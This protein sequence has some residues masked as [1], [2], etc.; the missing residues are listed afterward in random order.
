MTH[1]LV[2]NSILVEWARP[3]IPHLSAALLHFVWQGALVASLAALALRLLMARSSA[4]A[5]YAVL[6]ISFALMAVCPVATYCLSVAGS[7]S[8]R[9]VNSSVAETGS[10]SDEAPLSPA[11][12]GQS[13]Q[14]ADSPDSSI[15][16]N[17][18]TA[19]RMAAAAVPGTAST[20]QLESQATGE[21]L[22]H[23]TWSESVGSAVDR[24]RRWAGAHAT[25]IVLA[26]LCGV[27]LLSLRLAAGLYGAQRIQRIGVRSVSDSLEKM[28]VDLSS[29]LRVRRVVRVIES[30]VAEVPT[31]VGWLKPAIL[32]PASALT[33]LTNPQLESLLAHELA[34]ILRHDALVNFLQS[35][36]ETLFFYHPAV[37]WLSSRIREEREYCCDEIVIESLGDRVGYSRAL[38]TLAGLHP[39]QT[40]A[41]VAATGGSLTMRIQ[42]I[43]GKP[44][45]SRSAAGACVLGIAAASLCLVAAAVCWPDR[46]AVASNA[47]VNAGLTDTEND[48]FVEMPNP[49]ADDDKGDLT[50]SVVT[51]DGMPV[52]GIEVR[53]YRNQEPEL[54]MTGRTNDRGE[55][56]YPRRWQNHA[57]EPDAGVTLFAIDG[58]KRIGWFSFAG[59]Y[60]HQRQSAASSGSS[61]APGVPDPV[62]L[63]LL[64]LERSVTGQIVNEAKRPLANIRVQVVSLVNR[65]YFATGVSWLHY[66]DAESPLPQMSTDQEGRFRLLLPL[67]T[68]FAIAVRSPDWIAQRSFRGPTDD[69]RSGNAPINLGPIAMIPGGRIE[70][71]IAEKITGRPLGGVKIQARGITSQGGFGGFG[72]ARSDQNGRFHLDG[73]RPDFYGVT[74]QGAPSQPKLVADV[75]DSVRVVAGKAAR[76]DFG[77]FPGIPIRGRVIDAAT[78]KPLPKERVYASVSKGVDDGPCY[79]S[80]STGTDERGQFTL[81]VPTGICALSLDTTSAVETLPDSKRT[82]EIAEGGSLDAVVLKRGRQRRADAPGRERKVAVSTKTTTTT[83]T[84]APASRGRQVAERTSAP[85]RPSLAVELRTKSDRPIGEVH[86]RHIMVGR[87]SPYMWS[88][89]VGPRF[90]TEFMDS[91]VGRTAFLLIDTPGFAQARTSE[92]VI[93]P[94]LKPLIVDLEPGIPVPI[95]GLVLDRDQR[96]LPAARIRVR[97]IIYGTDSQFPWG[98]ESTSDAQGRFRV[99][100]ARVGD[101]VVIR[102]DGPNGDGA[103]SPAI[104]IENATPLTLPD[105]KLDAPN[106][107]ISGLV[108][109]QNRKLTPDV[110]VTYNNGAKHETKTDRNGRF[111]LGGLPGGRVSLSFLT[112]DGTEITRLIEAGST[113]ADIFLP[114]YSLYN[115]PE[116]RVTIQLH[117][118]DGKVPSNAQYYVVD[119]ESHR[120]L[121]SGGFDRRLE[122]DV[123]LG[124][125]GRTANRDRVA[126]VVQAE[127][128]AVPAPVPIS[129]DPAK[130]MTI[131]LQAAPAISLTGRVVGEDGKPIR[132]ARLG[133]S[134]TLA[135]SV[136]YTSWKFVS[137]MPE[138]PVEVDHD[139]RFTFAGLSP[140]MKVAVYANAPGY[141]GVWSD[142]VTLGAQDVKLDLRLARSTRTVSGR[143]VDADQHPVRGA[144][145]RIHD[146]GGPQTKSDESGQFRLTAVPDGKLVLFVTAYGYRDETRMLTTE[147]AS[148]EV[149]VKLATAPDVLLPASH[150][151]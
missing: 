12:V 136:E 89:K 127:G 67:Q 54:E 37:W 151:R 137:N 129:V 145:L 147:D 1:N 20:R 46:F 58:Q 29:R 22:A 125:V 86:V 93:G 49:G 120:W 119:R 113:N 72:N 73:L 9:E 36:F 77:C 59:H 78:N 23:G 102:V 17:S 149:I 108:H 146:F 92:F 100:H 25:G 68:D 70:G 19:K 131:D 43:L 57:G 118:S 122:R 110:L 39:L 112:E 18:L 133:L 50:G 97:R 140:G 30:A 101:T 24:F 87:N 139:G 75:P 11:L 99:K 150:G 41:A 98:P 121:Q 42:R 114:Q 15:S 35:A 13:S 103:D 21:R 32:L 141:A 126:V 74:L 88:L 5:R 48:S 117:T 144:F 62:R 47:D 56:Q 44:E 91:E 14:Q 82:F 10:A 45:P 52:A 123:D 130:H 60:Y 53:A 95:E 76:V 85:S 142:H 94:N 104:R 71:R 7:Q 84:A 116:N 64:P 109:D 134:F 124:R 65:S 90:E 66:P 40:P 6:L 28:I 63:V 27:A 83:E 105:F 135:D 51:P 3:I 132:D 115:R 26:W 31:V 128:Y 148:R 81:Y 34:H 61:S 80:R 106:R 8:A 96:P 16:N 33:G 55:F 138:K 107:E 69:E 4:Y 143:V 111:R 79:F 2:A 38:A